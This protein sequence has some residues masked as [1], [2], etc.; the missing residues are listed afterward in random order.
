MKSE[1]R[2]AHCAAVLVNDPAIHERDKTFVDACLAQIRRLYE[3]LY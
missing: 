2:L 3:L 1:K